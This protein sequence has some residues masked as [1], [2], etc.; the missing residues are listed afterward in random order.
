[1]I[2]ATSAFDWLAKICTTPDVSLIL[3]IENPEVRNTV[4]GV[5]TQ[6]PIILA[7][8]QQIGIPWAKDMSFGE[9]ETHM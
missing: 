9:L 6:L 4:I 2:M 5:E 3:E 8:A 1:M 7:H